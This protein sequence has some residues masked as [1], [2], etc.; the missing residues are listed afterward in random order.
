VQRQLE[1]ITA[2]LQLQFQRIAQLQAQLDRALSEH[3]IP[4]PR[5][6][7]RRAIPRRN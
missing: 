2:E 3:A 5:P 6:T 1:S 7:E 4:S